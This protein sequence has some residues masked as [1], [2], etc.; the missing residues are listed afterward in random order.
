MRRLYADAGRLEASW[1]GF[2]LCFH[3][4]VVCTSKSWTRYP[5]AL[6]A[7]LQRVVPDDRILAVVHR[8]SYSPGGSCTSHPCGGSRGLPAA[9][10]GCLRGW[11]TSEGQVTRCREFVQQNIKRFCNDYSFVTDLPSF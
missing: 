5:K 7:Q 1:E 10:R 9:P 11:V 4:P 2:H 6:L 3:S 8:L